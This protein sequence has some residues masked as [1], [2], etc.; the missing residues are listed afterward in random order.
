MVSVRP[1][2]RAAAVH[3]VGLGSAATGML[4][5]LQGCQHSVKVRRT[6]N[7]C[8]GRVSWSLV[9][10]WM[11]PLFTRT[12]E[13]FRMGLG[14]P[15]LPYDDD[16]AHGSPA[17]PLP[18]L[19]YDDDGAHGS[20]AEPLPQ[21]PPLFIGEEK[22]AQRRFCTY[23][24][25]HA[26]LETLGGLHLHS[27]PPFPPPP[28]SPA[29][30][31]LETL[32]GMHLHSIPPSPPPPNP[33]P[34]LGC[35]G[36]SG[37]VVSRPGHWPPPVQLVGF[38]HMRSSA[39]LTAQQAQRSRAAAELAALR[40]TL[41]VDFGSMGSLGLLGGGVEWLADVLAAVAQRLQIHVI[42]LTGGPWVRVGVR[43][44]VRV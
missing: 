36:I 26:L 3:A 12:W 7:G 33:L 17:E 41:C 31:L 16:G 37:S 18:P 22:D 14:L 28:H 43:I 15:P 9:A 19:P 27:I 13:R 2:I 8:A 1:S 34:V 24:A 25:G 38:L 44:G 20:P 35:A 39:W 42:V 23:K 6:L 32:G 4:V 29:H 10:A 5:Q 30:A 21:A 40:E 11:W